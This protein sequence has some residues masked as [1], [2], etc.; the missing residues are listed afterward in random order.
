V[1]FNVEL[2]PGGKVNA[3]SDGR[4]VQIQGA[5]ATWSRNDDEL[6]LVIAHE[7]AHN[8]LGHH[9]QL[10]QEDISTGLFSGF[11]ANG[12]KLRDMEREADRYSIFLVAR[13][14]YDFH[15][16]STFWRRLAK[17]SGIGSIWTTSHP[18]ARNR[19]RNADAAVAEVD[20]QLS[21]G[22]ALMP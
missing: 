8:F 2:V 18:N 22:T 11:G 3:G 4:L 5:L 21:K 14:R 10:D 9:E 15:I 1:R 16:A 17:S 20:E 13:A 12:R 7:M 6:A 19:G